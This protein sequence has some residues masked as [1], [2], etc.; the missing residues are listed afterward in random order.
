MKDVRA[1]NFQVVPLDNEGYLVNA[2]IIPVPKE[3][4]SQSSGIPMLEMFGRKR[5]QNEDIKFF[6]NDSQHVGMAMQDIIDQITIRSG[7]KV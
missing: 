5:K 3:E 7:T 2:E 1:I 4:D 6:A